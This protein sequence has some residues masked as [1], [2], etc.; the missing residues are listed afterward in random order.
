MIK[1]ADFLEVGNLDLPFLVLESLK[2]LSLSLF[3][4]LLLDFDQ[5][6]LGG[7]SLQVFTGLL[8]ALL[9]REQDLPK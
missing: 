3:L 8:A 9:M 1:L 7:L 4:H 6:L 2:H 5:P